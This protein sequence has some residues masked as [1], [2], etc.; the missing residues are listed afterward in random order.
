MYTKVTR[1]LYSAGDF[2]AYVACCPSVI[3]TS[4]PPSMIGAVC[5]MVTRIGSME[6][7]LELR[8]YMQSGGD[9]F[10]LR[11]SKRKRTLVLSLSHDG[12]IKIKQELEGGKVSFNE[13]QKLSA[14]IMTTHLCTYT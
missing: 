3:P 8:L 4:P 13:L 1:L 6:N 12:H 5:L 10:L 7:S 9:C 11:E 2:G 14:V